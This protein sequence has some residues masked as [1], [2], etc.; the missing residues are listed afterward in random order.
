MF[1][2]M[3]ILNSQSSV[4][5]NLW[6]AIV[7][8]ILIILSFLVT[9]YM[10]VATFAYLALAT[11]LLFRKNRKLHVS[12]MHLGMILDVS[13]VLILE[14]QRSA[15]GTA[16]GPTLNGFQTAHVIA[17]TLAIIFY[18]PTYYLGFYRWKGLDK[19]KNKRTWHIRFALTAFCLRTI[20]FLLMFS[21]LGLQH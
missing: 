2:A 5:L 9:P 20:G 18:V 13:L 7:L 19:D 10:V 1:P 8:S 6:I 11:G 17:S 3:D 16:L 4:K 12:L 15:I 14:I 21:M